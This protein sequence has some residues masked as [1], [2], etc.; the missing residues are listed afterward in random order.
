MRSETSQYRFESL[1]LLIIYD[2]I[3]RIGDN[4][5]Y[6]EKVGFSKNIDSLNR[7][8]CQQHQHIFYMKS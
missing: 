1:A 6:Q 4:T 2:H 5:N 7:K 3:I 8:Y